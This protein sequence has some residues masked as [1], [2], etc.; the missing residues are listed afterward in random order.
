MA[1]VMLNDI[2][3][4]VMEFNAS[5]VRSKKAVGNRV[6]QIT[7]SRCAPQIFANFSCSELKLRAFSRQIDERIR[8]GTEARGTDY[9]RGGRHVLRRSGRHAGVRS[10][11]LLI[12]VAGPHFG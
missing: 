2:G 9:G 3:F 4:D 6:K 11:G 10:H 1:H 8:L 7:N 12:S 5:D